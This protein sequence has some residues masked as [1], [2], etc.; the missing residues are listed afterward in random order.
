MGKGRREEEEKEKE[1]KEIGEEEGSRKTDRCQGN[2]GNLHFVKLS[3]G[4]SR[5]RPGARRM[6]GEGGRA[7][8]GGIG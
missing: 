8:Q 7:E 2:E 5:T 4:S 3:L 6:K 1:E